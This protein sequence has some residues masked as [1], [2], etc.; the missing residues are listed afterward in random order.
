MKREQES[1]KNDEGHSGTIYSANNGKGNANNGKGSANS[2]IN[3]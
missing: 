2:G 1:T 3:N